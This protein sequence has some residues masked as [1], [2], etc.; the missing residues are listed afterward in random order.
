MTVSDWTIEVASHRVRRNYS[1]G[2]FRHYRYGEELPEEPFAYWEA[3]FTVYRP[4][5]PGQ[6]EVVLDGTASADSEEG[7]EVCIV[8]EARALIKDWKNRQAVAARATAHLN[9]KEVTA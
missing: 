6:S 3:E 1:Y 5:I 8:N 9:T 2:A 4:E 7:L